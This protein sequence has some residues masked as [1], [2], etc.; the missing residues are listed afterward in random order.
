MTRWL[1]PL[2]SPEQTTS[3]VFSCCCL[4]CI[5]W[6]TFW[7][8]RSS[9]RTNRLSSL[10]WCLGDLRCTSVCSRLDQLIRSWCHENYLCK[11][12]EQYYYI[13]P[14][15][16][17]HYEADTLSHN[18]TYAYIILENVIRNSFV[19]AVVFE[20]LVTSVAVNIVP[21][22]PYTIYWNSR[23]FHTQGICTYISAGYIDA[24]V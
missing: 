1:L 11:I 15:F 22:S 14:S 5:F 12:T 13:H 23:L 4:S 20:A 3:L 6:T 7:L 9:N 24:I 18:I 8:H 17:W 10:A 21:F 2:S 19:T 16:P